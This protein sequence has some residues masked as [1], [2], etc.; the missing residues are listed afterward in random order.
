MEVR[1][2]STESLDS[3]K[4]WQK[5]TFNQADTVGTTAQQI[6]ESTASWLR[7]GKSFTEAQDAAVASNWLLNVSEFQNI[8]DAT[9]ALMS[10]TQAFNDLS[11][12]N[13]IDSLNAVGDHYSSAT[14]QLASGLQNAAAVLKI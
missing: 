8:D 6:Q 4:E 1:K 12:E 13:V 3:L 2:V 11:F 5:I 7:L 9:T 10:I 14:D